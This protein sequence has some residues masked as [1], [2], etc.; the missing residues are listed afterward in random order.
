MTTTVKKYAAA[1]SAVQINKNQS[2]LCFHSED[3]SFNMFFISLNAEKYLFIGTLVHESIIEHSFSLFI[4]GISMPF[5]PAKNE[6]SLHNAP[7]KKV[8]F[9]KYPAGRIF[10]FA[11]SPNTFFISSHNAFDF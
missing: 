8:S 10:A 7:F 6:M 11:L 5:L 4:G 1:A 9:T 2:S 3:F